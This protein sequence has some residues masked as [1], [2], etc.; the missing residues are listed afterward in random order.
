MGWVLARL[1]TSGCAHN[2][3]PT[4]APLIFV[5]RLPC[6]VSPCGM[7]VN[8][9]WRRRRTAR[10]HYRPESY[11]NLC[12]HPSPRTT[13]GPALLALQCVKSIPSWL[14]LRALGHRLPSLYTSRLALLRLRNVAEPK[15]PGPHWVRVRP[16]ISGVCGSDLASI[17]AAG[18]PFFV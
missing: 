18:S 12:D 14:L 3:S 4:H 1:V 16:T 15:L 9:S 11:V 10:C 2:R 17:T 5:S 8:A 7:G 6:I 13:D